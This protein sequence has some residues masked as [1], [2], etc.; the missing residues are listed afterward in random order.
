[1]NA[2]APMESAQLR[3][4]LVKGPTGDVAVRRVIGVAIFTVE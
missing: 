2:G 1:M 3:S 4:E